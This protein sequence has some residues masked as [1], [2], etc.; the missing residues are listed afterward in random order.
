M[1]TISWRSSWLT[2]VIGLFVLAVIGIASIVAYVGKEKERDLRS[3]ETLLGVVADGRVQSVGQWVD[4]QSQV[5]K[6]LAENASL[7]FY[8]SQLAAGG[9]AASGAEAAQVT[10]LRNLLESTAVRTGFSDCFGAGQGASQY[11]CGFR[12]R[13]CHS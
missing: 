1:K 3:W 5:F 2:A 4:T 12:F 6:E 11:R 10:Y 7:R 9:D 13:H 8:M